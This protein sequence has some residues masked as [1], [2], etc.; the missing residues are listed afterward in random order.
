VYDQL[1]QLLPPY[2]NLGLNREP[3]LG[4]MEVDAILSLWTR[5][6]G[7]ADFAV[8]AKLAIRDSEALM[9]Q[10]D[11]LRA[12]TGLDVVLVTKYANPAVRAKCVERGF[13]YADSMG[14]IR[15][16][17]RQAALFVVR[18]GAARPPRSDRKSDAVRLNGA[19]A[20]K[21][22]RALLLMDPPVGVRELAGEAAVNPGSA[23]KV[24][25]TLATAGCVERDDKGA[26]LVIRRRLLLER[27]IQDYSFV[28]GNQDV[29]WWVDPRG[30][31]STLKRLKGQPKIA[32]TGSLVTRA[33][34]PPDTVAVKPLTLA[35]LYA[36]EP[37]KIAERLR[38]IPAMPSQANVVLARPRDETLLWSE[39]TGESLP[40]V[41]LAQ[42]LA[43]L[44]TLPGRSVEEAE[45]VM[46]VLSWTDP[47]W[48][49]EV[50]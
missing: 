2:W 33:W 8:E 12:T 3:P 42:A 20:S 43:D 23:A 15:L 13:S 50:S 28:Q 26:V 24:L 49:A 30:I 48:S 37:L 45:Q 22:I 10:M 32:L 11:R 36:G 14:W 9:W 34:L 21:I 7:R 4:G 16:E 39:G 31:E 29:T 27:W 35:A 18:P 38:L 41:P 40:R 25:P 19:G 6:T 44:L 46:E 47:S 5:E 17:S 1:R